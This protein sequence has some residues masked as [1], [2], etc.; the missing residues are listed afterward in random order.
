MDGVHLSYFLTR[1][2]Y[3]IVREMKKRRRVNVMTTEKLYYDNQY[4]RSFTSKLLKQ[5]K[6]E[7]G[8]IY[9][10]LEKTAFYPTGGGQPHDIGTINGI[11]VVD[12]VEVDGEIRHFIEKQ[13]DEQN[14]CNCEI[15]WDR[16]FDHMQQHAGQHILSAAFEETHGYKTISFHLGKEIC[17]IDLDIANLTEE[18]ADAVEKLANHIII[19]NLPIEAK[20][21][22][23]SEL[24]HYSL[25]K[26]LSVSENIRLVII[27]N[28]DYNGCGGTHPSSTG[29]VQSLKILQWEKQKKHTRVQFVCGNRVITQLS[30]K[31]KVI[32]SLTGILNAPQDKMEEAANRI[33]KQSK[34]F[35]KNLDEL[36]NKLL[37]Y[38]ASTLINEQQMV[39]N[40]KIV[41]KIFYNYSIPD[42]QKLART[43]V[44]KTNDVLV[45]FINEQEDKLQFVCAK[46]PELP[47]NMNEVVK[48]NIPL[49]NGKGGGNDSFA[50]GGGEKL[51]SANQLMDELV[52]SVR[53]LKNGK[54]S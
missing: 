34:E 24:E 37:D 14:E 19:E 41:K 21:V 29:Q 49:V 52:S 40:I 23:E 27:P 46:G 10:V 22:T 4:I 15:N 28:F 35:E 1:I 12:V 18:E 45:F 38:E 32:Q 30:Q 6:D 33:L 43:I 3:A 16:R 42:L 54:Y 26:E 39:D 17:T 53:T 13:I 5:D 31:Q 51:L 8:R 25:R 7:N 2:T 36:K 47:F 9:I 11:N 20:W 44:G 48:R 50:Q